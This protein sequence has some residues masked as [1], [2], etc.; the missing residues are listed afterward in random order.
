MSDFISFVV[1]GFIGLFIAIFIICA[2]ISPTSINVYKNAD[3][4]SGILVV[5]GK[6]IKSD[7]ISVSIGNFMRANCNLNCYY[8]VVI[9]D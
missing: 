2:A 6:P 4:N 7:N 9:K 3:G 1:G 5:D 8:R